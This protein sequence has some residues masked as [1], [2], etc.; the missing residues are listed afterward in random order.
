[1][2][3]SRLRVEFRDFFPNFDPSDNFLVSAL[4]Q[5]T[6][7]EV[8]SGA[9]LC[10]FSDF[11]DAHV[12]FNGC[13]VQ[14]SGENRRPRYGAADF[15]IGFD[16]RVDERYLRYP[17]WAWD[18]DTTALLVPSA[19]RCPDPAAEFCAFVVMNPSNPVRNELFRALSEQRF[20]HAPGAVF[21][22]TEGIG[23]RL[24]AHWRTT[25]IDYLRD[26]RFTIAAENGAHPG[27]TTE[28]IVD[29][30]L[31]GS[32]PIYWGDPLVDRDFNPAA[33]INFADHFT[34]SRTV[35]V[36]LDVEA[37]PA[38]LARLRAEPP[39]TAAAWN[40][41]GNPDRVVEFLERVLRW[42]ATAQEAGAWRHRVARLQARRWAHVAIDRLRG[43]A[44]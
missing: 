13:K 18:L 35:Q 14:V 10:F 29:A 42:R 5:L 7:V 1:V 34:V 37:D 2:I 4:R 9:D 17:L 22:N 26:F 15:A 3:P 11:G 28:K 32:V 40:T 39:M 12:S 38:A 6:E 8:G 33:F 21:H 41:S 16:R 25:K 27:Y 19:E 36:V 44:S 43:A 24:D 20:V 23:P 30:F 31:A